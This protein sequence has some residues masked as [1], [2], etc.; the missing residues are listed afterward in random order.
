MGNLAAADA[1]VIRTPFAPAESKGAP[2][3]VIKLS[4]S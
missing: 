3:T 1:L 2:C 4:L